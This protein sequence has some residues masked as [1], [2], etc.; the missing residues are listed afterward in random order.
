VERGTHEKLLAMD[1]VYHRLYTSQ[2]RD[3]AIVNS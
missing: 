3:Q 2:F 1:G